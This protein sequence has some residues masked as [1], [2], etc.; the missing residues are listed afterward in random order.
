MWARF[1][2]TTEVDALATWIAGELMRAVSAANAL[3]PPKKEG[4]KLR[5]LDL[6]VAQRVGALAGGLNFYK[7]ARLG[8]Q[9]KAALLE[10]GYP[11]EFAARYSTELVALA[12]VAGTRKKG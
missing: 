5:R 1:L 7:K 10:A 3:A 4:E 8:G 9:V 12:A 11:A 6:Q 2:D